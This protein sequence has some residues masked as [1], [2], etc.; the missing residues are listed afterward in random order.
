MYKN[1]KR[2][3]KKKKGSFQLI[4]IKKRKK[5]GKQEILKSYPHYP[6]KNPQFWWIILGEKRTNVLLNYHEIRIVS[7][8]REKNIDF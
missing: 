6:H 3:R 1:V 7:K 8:K 5:R 2:C 4:H